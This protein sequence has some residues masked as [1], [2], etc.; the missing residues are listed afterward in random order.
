MLGVRCNH[1]RE[2]RAITWILGHKRREFEGITTRQVA[3]VLWHVFMDARQFFSLTV[4]L[5]GSLPE[6]NL[7]VVWGMITMTM[8]QECPI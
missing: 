2:V 1:F 5:S 4:N 7:R 3:T 8:S 6:S